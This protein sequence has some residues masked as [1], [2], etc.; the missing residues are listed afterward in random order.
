[1]TSNEIVN[2]NSSALDENSLENTLKINTLAPKTS[3][4]N[5]NNRLPSR[6][7]S[8]PGSRAASSPQITERRT[9]NTVKLRENLNNSSKDESNLIS[10]IHYDTSV[11]TN[12]SNSRPSSTSQNLRQ[13]N[14]KTS[15]SPLLTI[16]PR[17]SPPFFT[18]ETLCEETS[19]ELGSKTSE[20][21]IN[22]NEKKENNNQTLPSIPSTNTSSKNLPTSVVNMTTHFGLNHTSYTTEQNILNGYKQKNEKNLKSL[23][24]K[25]PFSSSSLK[26][27]TSSTN[28]FNP[29]D[30]IISSFIKLEGVSPLLHHS[31]SSSPT[32]SNIEHFAKNNFK[33]KN[34]VVKSPISNQIKPVKL[35]SNVLSNLNVT[36]NGHSEEEVDP[37]DYLLENMNTN[38]I[39]SNE[40]P[41]Y[42]PST[43]RKPLDTVSPDTPWPLISFDQ[44]GGDS[45]DSTDILSDS[46][47]DSSTQIQPPSPSS[48]TPFYNYTVAS[49]MNTINKLNNPAILPLTAEENM[50]NKRIM[51]SKSLPN[52]TSKKVLTST[53]S[54]S[55]IHQPPSNIM[56]C[57]H[58]MKK[59]SVWWCPS[60]SRSYCLKCWPLE[61]HHSKTKDIISTHD[62]LNS[63]SNEVIKKKLNE[64]NKSTTDL[65][66]HKPLFLHSNEDG[67]LGYRDDVETLVKTVESMPFIHLSPPEG[68]KVG[69][70][71]YKVKS[72][73]L[74]FKENI[75]ITSP[76]NYE[77]TII[78]SSPSR[79]G[80]SNSNCSPFLEDATDEILYPHLRPA[81]TPWRPPPSRAHDIGEVPLHISSNGHLM[82][83]T[84]SFYD[85]LEEKNK[86]KSQKITSNKNILIHLTSTNQYNDSLS[87]RNLSTNL[88]LNCSS[89]SYSNFNSTIIDS[90]E[91]KFQKHVS[92]TWKNPNKNISLKKDPYA[93]LNQIK[94]RKANEILSKKGVKLNTVQLTNIVNNLELPI[95]INSTAISSTKQTDS[96]STINDWKSGKINLNP[97]G[98][99][100]KNN[101]SSNSPNKK[102]FEE[103][104]SEKEKIIQ[105]KKTLP[106]KFNELNI[107]SKS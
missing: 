40:E 12:L 106:M 5:D 82:Q 80:S 2:G 76:M 99:S 60:C 72:K 50:K 15:D 59:V 38:H 58:C 105:S 77:P 41:L 66:S 93:K 71:N 36:K 78:C 57:S 20:E 81:Q 84:N 3:Q 19:Y 100:S 44:F 45:L 46:A 62:S 6:S 56:I 35:N 102:L 4:S 52:L 86:L 43:W 32:S 16:S 63:T 74:K 75:L 103:R 70:L 14:A 18:D 107:F 31:P 69:D 91:K 28:T 26:K 8:R 101:F 9:L 13:N 96:D 97:E 42:N 11:N 7:S 88:S 10:M 67:G 90:E 79:P 68:E 85:H 83:H 49:R 22:E 64:L 24:I 33:N 51:N 92:S 34:V 61:A 23:Q 54:S 25:K 48:S 27:P 95:D 94:N 47:Q 55:F 37:H 1:M 65:L 30:E 104:L 29:P 73:D 39:N 53:N 98:E 17:P 87:P 89:H 21:K